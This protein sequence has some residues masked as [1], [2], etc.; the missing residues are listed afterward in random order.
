[1]T[2]VLDTDVASYILKKDTRA[3]QYR[4]IIGSA[5]LMLPF[6]AEAELL[7]WAELHQWQSAKLQLL[8]DFVA[9]VRVVHSSRALAQTWARVMVDARRKGRRM[10]VADAWMAATALL[11]D[12]PLVTNNEK[13]YRA[14]AGL[15]LLT[16]SDWRTEN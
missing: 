6:M 13:D 2:V 3:A 1:M 14:V 7:Q 5:E 12:L 11:Y 8:A 15:R 16:A 9:R 10:D 4:E